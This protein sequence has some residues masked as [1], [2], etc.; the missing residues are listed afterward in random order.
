MFALRM[1]VTPIN[2][3]ISFSFPIYCILKISE[4]AQEMFH[5]IAELRA[6]FSRKK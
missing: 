3:I 5:Q 1:F 2:P 6:G 4:H